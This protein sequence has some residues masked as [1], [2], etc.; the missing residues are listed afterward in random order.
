MSCVISGQPT[1]KL[2]REPEP[3]WNLAGHIPKLVLI[4]APGALIG[5]PSVKNTP[6]RIVGKN[7]DG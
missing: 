4:I 3:N 5:W 7:S 2:E 6:R 1:S